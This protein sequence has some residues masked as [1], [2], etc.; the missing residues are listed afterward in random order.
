M[1]ASVTAGCTSRSTP[2]ARPTPTAS[3]RPDPDVTLA[4]G[5]LGDER[6]ML[7][8]VQATIR[9][10]RRLGA[11]LAGSRATHQ[12]HVALLTEVATAPSGTPS[13]R[14]RPGHLRVPRRPGP[15][16]LALARAEAQLSG[17]AGAHAGAAPSGSFARAIASMAAAAAQQATHLT[18]LAQQQP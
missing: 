3:G 8:R 15:A 6:T 4:A 11:A 17:L 16:L 5:V 10:H 18:T 14:P 7:A 1:L 9:R 2:A 13:S 12:A